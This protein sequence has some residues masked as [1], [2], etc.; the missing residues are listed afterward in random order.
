MN[1]ANPQPYNG[2]YSDGVVRLPPLTP[3]VP[4]DSQTYQSAASD[5]SDRANPVAWDEPYEQDGAPNQSYTPNPPKRSSKHVVYAIELLIFTFVGWGWL[6]IR[7]FMG[8]TPVMDV[9][10]LLCL[11]ISA[12][13]NLALAL[14][15]YTTDQFMGAAQGFFAH[16]L[17]LWMLYVYSLIESTTSGWGPL[18]CSGGA[19]TFSVTKTYANAY[20]GGLPFH[21]TAGAV[22][23]AFL[24]VFLILAAGQ[25]RVCLEDPR[26]WLV[27]QITISVA[28]LISF[29]VGLFAL[30]AKVCGSEMGGAVIGIATAAWLLMADTQWAFFCVVPVERV[31]IQR[32][33]ELAFTA[34]LAGVAGGLS[35]SI[36]GSVSSAL[37]L[38]LGGVLVWQTA[39]LAG[40]VYAWRRATAQHIANE[41]TLAPLV[42]LV[43]LQSRFRNG[44]TNNNCNTNYRPVMPLPG[45]REI[46]LQQ[47]RE[48]KGW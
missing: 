36:G 34:L 6:G 38:S 26:E 19:S 12:T 46:R 42:P 39:A 11:L 9:S 10:V 24:S 31:V 20:F 40:I 30:N 43:P 18:C 29:H 44:Y 48:K 37:M 45:V 22:T 28:C 47:K 1:V 17:S 32:S 16:T 33:L 21:Q 7:E 14:I 23:L 2:P 15:Y 35:T 8:A 5:N 27:G 4:D 13:F 41:D 25:V 3:V